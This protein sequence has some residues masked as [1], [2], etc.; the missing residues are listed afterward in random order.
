VRRRQF[1]RMLAFSTVAAGCSSMGGNLLAAT[2]HCRAD[3]HARTARVWAW[4]RMVGTADGIPTSE[5][6]YAAHRSLIH[7][8]MPLH[9]GKLQADG[10][11]LQEPWKT[12]TD[13]A[14]SLRY[15]A[16][17]AGQ[18]YLPGVGNDREGIKA[19]LDSS[20]LMER[21]A[22]DLLRL[23]VERFDAPWDGVTLDLEG[24]PLEYREKL[25][26]FLQLLV[27]R[28]K[29]AGLLACISIQG[30][31]GDEGPDPPDTYTYDF[32]IVGALA[33]YVDL[34]CYGYWAPPPRSIGPY[35]WEEACIGYATAKG[36]A[37]GRILLGPGT[38][39][40]YYFDSNENDSD[41][42][43]YEQALQVVELAGGT[44]EWVETGD[45]GLVRER[46]AKVGAGHVWLRDALTH[47]YAL[48]LVEEFGLLGI[49]LFS[50][51]M[52][53]PLQWQVTQDW[54]L[55]HRY[56][57]PQIAGHD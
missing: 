45:A 42:I 26:A 52:E 17:K 22:D 11:W 16:K 34:R 2:Q 3:L 54:L 15:A 4:L 39:A 23:A 21:A 1:L 38:F 57:L 50:P 37:A 53:D 44:L 7:A 35:W 8:A 18:L 41:E 6:S 46:F 56:F 48:D 12:E 49:S 47:R 36:I 32:S 55:R 5:S 28:I 13:W 30:R 24:I 31:S 9:G 33:D 43:T 27:R 40:K 20:L 29:D 25:S 14:R 51:G 10:L 19:V